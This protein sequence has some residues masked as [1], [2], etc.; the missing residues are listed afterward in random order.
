MNIGSLQSLMG[1][2]S[3][4][5][6]GNSV[7]SAAT[8]TAGNE[9]F[10]SIF[11]A[12]SLGASQREKTGDLAKGDNLQLELLGELFKATDLSE[13]EEAI[14][15]I[16]NPEFSFEGLS[17]M[18]NGT[19]SLKEIAEKTSI[20]LEQ[21]IESLRTLCKESGLLKEQVDDLDEQATLW[22]LISLVE[23]ASPQ[24][25]DKLL[26]TLS[27]IENG[28][29]KK[30]PTSIDFKMAEGIANHPLFS[31]MHATTH[32]NSNT[33]N[34]EVLSPEE[35]IDILKVLKVAELAVPKMD[36]TTSMEQKVE[37]FTSSM[38]QLAIQF[39]ENMPKHQDG[40]VNML[41]FAQKAS[42]F[43]ILTGTSEAGLDH[44]QKEQPNSQ[45]KS[46][47]PVAVNH[48]AVQHTVHKSDA[49]TVHT[50]QTQENRSETLMKE[51]QMLFKRANFGQVGGSNRMLIKLYPEHLGQ[52]RIELHEMNGV[53]SA[54]ILASTALAK[55]MLDSQMHQLRQAFNQQNVQVD[56][57][58][59]TQS[60]QEPAKERE[61]AF[62]EQY[63][64]EQQSEEGKKE[65]NADA[66]TTFEEYLIELEV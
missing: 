17:D 26:S 48:Q 13:V 54:R 10:G 44:Q 15:V 1:T 14:R 24:I 27:T 45:S 61:Q 7:D 34:P 3:A 38:Q 43:R 35:A 20:D 41:Q 51:M 58:D 42:T 57:I 47:Q 18:M 25:F 37:S 40:K 56:R 60:V 4:S 23:E 50:A 52:I 12:L 30:Q 63:K 16:G 49:M 28:A 55:E 2:I 59:I 39:D 32:P 66:E 6:K 33:G 65:Q 36:M 53:V 31:K 22:N 8:L 64:R 21:L 29:G 62:N 11:G 9:S 46:E 19:T 5:S